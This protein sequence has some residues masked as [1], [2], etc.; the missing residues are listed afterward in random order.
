M[1]IASFVSANDICL[2]D[3]QWSVERFRAFAR[4]FSLGLVPLN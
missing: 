4:R 3:K 1:N 2:N